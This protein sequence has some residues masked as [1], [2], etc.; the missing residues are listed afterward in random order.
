MKVFVL[1]IVKNV[2]LECGLCFYFI[3]IVNINILGNWFELKVVD[4]KR[5]RNLIRLFSF[6][7]WIKRNFG[8][9]NC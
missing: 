5:K 8:M 2:C 1:G 4:L 6:L 3:N 9:I 7:R